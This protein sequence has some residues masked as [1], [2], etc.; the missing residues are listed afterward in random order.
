MKK[1]IL[2]LRIILIILIIFFAYLAFYYFP[3]TIMNDQ[4]FL[5]NYSENERFFPIFIMIAIDALFCLSIIF[6]VVLFW[7]ISIYI[8]KD[9]LTSINVLKI[10][11]IILI[12]LSIALAVFIISNICFYN[13]KW[14]N[15]SIVFMFIFSSFG[16]AILIY[17]LFLYFMIKNQLSNIE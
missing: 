12:T 14:S 2:L 15:T 4:I 11:R 17:V 13:L 10:L 6:T 16:I 1:N 9:E 5:N 7:K 3:N 8:N